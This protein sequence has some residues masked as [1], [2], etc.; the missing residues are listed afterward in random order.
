MGMALGCD[1]EP[2]DIGRAVA[3]AEFIGFVTV[4]RRFVP[5]SEMAFIC[6]YVCCSVQ[7]YNMLTVYIIIITYLLSYCS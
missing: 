7:A 3:R 6:V 4:G 5:R 2:V 1:G